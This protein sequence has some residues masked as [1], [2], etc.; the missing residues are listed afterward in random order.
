MKIF[1]IITTTISGGSGP[2]IADAFNLAI[3]IGD[4]SVAPTDTV[5][6]AF[7]FPES[8]VSPTDTIALNIKG[9]GDTNV[10]PAD[11]LTKLGIGIA[12][13]NLSPVDVD[14]YV[15]NLAQADTNPVQ[16]EATIANIKGL[17]DTSTAPTDTNSFTVTFWLNGSTGSANVTNPTKADGANDGVTSTQQTTL[18][19]STQSNLTSLV[20]NN[21]PNGISF[22]SA[23]YRGWFKLTTTLAVTS[24]A[25]VTIHSSSALFADITMVV[26][27]SLNGVVDHLSGDFTFD[28][29]AAGVN[30]L[31]KLQSCQVI[32]NTS[33]A[34]AGVTPATAA[35]DAG[36]IELTGI[37]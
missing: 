12:D 30:T 6:F 36:R 37:F 25:S 20:G 29:I 22:S 21:I 16:T 7:T 14:K 31:A 5:K 24:S 10:V 18:A 35:V 17:G 27:S 26:L 19:G 4:S 32:T 33:D 9:L 11:S 13:T 3:T 34:T 28:L 8:T 2:P 23:V 15:I 1:P